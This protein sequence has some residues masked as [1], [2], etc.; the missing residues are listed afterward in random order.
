MVAFDLS[1][2]R[3]LQAEDGLQIEVGRLA[4]NIG[5]PHGIQHGPQDIQLELQDFQRPFLLLPGLEMFQGDGKSVFH[6]ATGLTDP[7]AKIRQS[8]RFD[9]RIFVWPARQALFVDGGGK[10]F[11]Q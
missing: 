9:P 4:V 11:R 3:H 7:L 10:H 5:Q 8:F 2:V 1:C 6:I